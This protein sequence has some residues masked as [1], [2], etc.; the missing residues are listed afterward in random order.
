MATTYLGTVNAPDFRPSLAWLNVERP[1]RL[2]HLRGR[3]VILDFWTY[4]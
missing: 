4:C 2:E 3:M 1:L